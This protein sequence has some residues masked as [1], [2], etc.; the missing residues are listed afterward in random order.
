MDIYLVVGPCTVGWEPDEHEI[1]FTRKNVGFGSLAFEGTL[2]FYLALF[3]EVVLFH[4][5]HL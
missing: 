4:L 2:S 1:T 3:R 5:H